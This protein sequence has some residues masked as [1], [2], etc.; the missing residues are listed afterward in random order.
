MTKPYHAV[1]VTLKRAIAHAALAPELCYELV[2]ATADG[3]RNLCSVPAR[4]GTE[5]Y[6]DNCEFELV[7]GYNIQGMPAACT[8]AFVKVL[9]AAAAAEH[10]TDETLATWMRMA[11]AYDAS[12]SLEQPTSGIKA[13]VPEKEGVD[14][15][16]QRLAEAKVSSTVMVGMSHRVDGCECA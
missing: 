14:W 2:V 10:V 4:G 1:N 13:V 8:F 6:G 11:K 9:L 5:E 15:K 12:F 3:Y 16:A 7:E